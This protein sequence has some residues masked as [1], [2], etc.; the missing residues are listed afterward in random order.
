LVHL[1]DLFTHSEIA[2]LTGC[3]STATCLHFIL[4]SAA[5]LS[6]LA[7]PAVRGSVEQ[8]QWSADGRALQDGHGDVLNAP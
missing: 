3:T 2:C 7:S 8:V 4:S 6:L 5:S 1:L